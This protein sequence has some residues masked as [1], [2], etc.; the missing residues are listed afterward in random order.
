VT[1]G[2]SVGARGITLRPWQAGDVGILHRSNTPAMTKHVGGPETDEAVEARQLRYM[3]MWET[4]EA[5]MFAIVESGKGADDVALGGAG[6]WPSMW[7]DQPVYEAGWGVVPEAQ[8]RGVAKAAVSLLIADARSHAERRLL[9]AFP[10]I[11]NVPSNSLCASAGFQSHGIESFPF[12]GTTLTVN[13]W[14]LEL[15]P[16]AAA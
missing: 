3:R 7:R 14:A 9:T 11:E 13:A 15:N 6:W 16:F 2:G 1:S 4:G 5:R 8:G 10:S 12:R